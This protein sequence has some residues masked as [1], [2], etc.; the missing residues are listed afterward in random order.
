[1]TDL[2]GKVA[3]VTGGS[4]GIGAAIAQR[5]ARAGAAV[6][7]TYVTA[8]GKAA[9]CRQADRR[10]RRTGARHPGGQLRSRAIVAAVEQTVQ[11]FGRIEISSNNAGG[12]H[13]RADRGSNCRAG[14]QDLG[15]LHVR[16]VLVASQAAAPHISEGGLD[17]HDRQRA[18]RSAFPRL[19]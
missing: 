5:L 9:G 14:R 11:E 12:V 6:A 4:R 17:H 10:G 16:A 13:R 19:A 15:L 8:A 1:M 18:D 7:F 2:T 3:L